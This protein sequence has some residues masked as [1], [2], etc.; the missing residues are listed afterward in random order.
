[1]LGSESIKLNLKLGQCSILNPTL[2]DIILS[3]VHFSPFLNGH[4]F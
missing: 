3:W 2:C 4:E 1:M